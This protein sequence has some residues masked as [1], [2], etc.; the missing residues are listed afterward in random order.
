MWFRLAKWAGIPNVE[1]KFPDTIVFKIA[2]IK[3]SR[4]T[5]KM[6]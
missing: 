3:I 5:F 2:V 1:S 6:A 4:L